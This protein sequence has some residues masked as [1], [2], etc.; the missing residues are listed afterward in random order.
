MKSFYVVTF[1]PFQPQGEDDPSNPFIEQAYQHEKFQV[2]E[3]LIPAIKFAKQVAKIDFFGEVTIRESV[4]K[5]SG[6]PEEIE[7]GYSLN[8]YK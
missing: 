5:S 3:G 7:G 2:F 4:M 8:V 6:N 1:T